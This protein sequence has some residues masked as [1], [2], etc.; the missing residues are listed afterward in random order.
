M[1]N[2][3]KSIIDKI[4]KANVKPTPKWVFFM[5][6][7]FVWGL[8]GASVL[9]GSIAFSII[10]FQFRD[11]DYD[12]YQQMDDG[13]IEFILL[14]L[15]YFWLILM[16]GFLLLANY[17]FRHTKGGYR[18]NVFAIIG[19]SLLASVILGSTLY[20]GGFS[21]K[22][23]NLFQEI[24]HYEKL[25]I[26]KRMLWQRPD[27]GRLAGTIKQVEKDKI[28][29]LEDMRKQTWWVD[30]NE[31]KLRL[32][33]K[34]EEGERIRMIGEKLNDKQFRAHMIAP[35]RIV[36]KLHMKKSENGELPPFPLRFK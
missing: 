3:S 20:A 12:L 17:H 15:P 22:L 30:I 10:F 2:L 9:L 36:K 34:L 28:L 7:S 5:K 6:N 32:D 13:V 21:E 24:P 4:K 35:W 27:H 25:H 16:A 14:A 33:L 18:Y 1:S 31:A 26:G 11:A 23:D 29:I 8:F 19:L